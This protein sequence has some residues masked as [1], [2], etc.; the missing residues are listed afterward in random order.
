MRRLRLKLSLRSRKRIRRDLREASLGI[1][2]KYK[3]EK[4]E[5]AK[6]EA[7]EIKK[8]A[9]EKVNVIK[10]SEALTVNFFGSRTKSLWS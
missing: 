7:E 8:T 4:R 2:K 9:T 10:I 3:K 5:I 1:E 6:T